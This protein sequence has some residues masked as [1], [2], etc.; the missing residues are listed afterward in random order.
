MTRTAATLLIGNEILTG[1]VEE[2]NLRPLAKLFFRLGVELQRVVTCQDKVEVIASDLTTLSAGHDYVVTSGGVGPTHDD[3]TIE[4]VAHAFDT[5]V[6]RSEELE[7]RIRR[8]V[9]DRLNNSHLRMADIPEGARV[10]EG[11]ENDWP[12]VQMANV[13]ILPGLPGIFRAKLPAL[14]QAIGA[15]R[16]FIS[17]AV[18]TTLHETDIATTL[19]TLEEAHVTVDI[20]SY[21]VLAQK[22]RVRI[23]FD[24]KHQ[25]A[26]DQAVADLLKAVP[27]EAIYTG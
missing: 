14:Q 1:K 3:V 26:I 9:G 19:R 7:G 23:T 2:C 27:K 6:V 12:I 5:R 25:E 4:G 10:V 15:T 11:D 22:Y 17:H 13:Y 21:P 18:Y 20:G 8:L 16:P 24:S